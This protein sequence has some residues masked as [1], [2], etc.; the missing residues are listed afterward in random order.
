MIEIFQA[1]PLL[2]VAPDNSTLVD[3]HAH[4]FDCDS[5][6]PHGGSPTV[7][8]FAEVMRLYTTPVAYRSDDLR[9][10]FDQPA[11]AAGWRVDE[12]WLQRGHTGDTVRYCKEANGRA[13]LAIMS[14]T[15]YAEEE[16]PAPAV[17]VSLSAGR[18]GT[19]CSLDT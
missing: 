18:A 12:L 2:A 16:P 1:D 19:T 11:A 3:E 15:V 14:A 7:P 10:L 13:S 5:G 4:T 6:L 9:E 8:G 17:R